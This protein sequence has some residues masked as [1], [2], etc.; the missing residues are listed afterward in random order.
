MKSEET[1]AL[2]RDIYAG[3]VIRE[4][5]DFD[6]LGGDEAAKKLAA[7]S[8]RL[9]NIFEAETLKVGTAKPRKK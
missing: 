6:C 9:A 1:A 4:N 8:L 7:S 3:L 5:I 2:A